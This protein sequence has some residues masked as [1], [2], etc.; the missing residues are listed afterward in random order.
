MHILLQFSLR[1]LDE[2]IGDDFFHFLGAEANPQNI[3]SIFRRLAV[4]QLLLTVLHF[5]QEHVVWIAETAHAL[6][7]ASSNT[8]ER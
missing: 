2:L 8:P 6:I 1:Y 3:Q 5:K 4:S 7:N